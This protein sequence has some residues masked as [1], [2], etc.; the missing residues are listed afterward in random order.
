MTHLS[1]RQ[2]AMMVKEKFN[3]GSFSHQTLK[4]YYNK[5]GTSYKRPD[6]RFWKSLAENQQLKEKQ[7][8]F[9][10]QLATMIKD[11]SYD[12]IIYVDETTFHLWMKLSK[13]WL[14][15]GMKLAMLK[16]RG[17]SITVIEQSAKRE[18]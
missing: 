1:L 13:C 10:Q 4:N 15:P 12:E 11:K 16:Y 8:E 7:L 9:V 6:Y 14:S 5:Y 17:P 18:A 3:M 2:R